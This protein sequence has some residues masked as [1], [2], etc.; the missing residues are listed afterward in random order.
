MQF[1]P[2]QAPPAVAD[3]V[4]DSAL[5]SI[6][7]GD[8]LGRVWQPPRPALPFDR[9]WIFHLR[10]RNSFVLAEAARIFP[11]QP[12]VP[13]AW[14]EHQYGA[15][16]DFPF[17]PES[18]TY[19]EDCAGLLDAALA[20]L[21]E[22][23]PAM[24]ALCLLPESEVRQAS[25]LKRA[26]FRPQ[27]RMCLETEILQERGFGQSSQ[28]VVLFSTDAPLFDPATT[29]DPLRQLTDDPVNLRIFSNAQ[30]KIR[31]QPTF[32]FW[33]AI[34]LYTTY[35]AYPFI[36]Q[37]LERLHSQFAIP[38][39]RRLLVTP[40]AGG[41]FLRLWPRGSGV[42]D[43]AAAVDIRPDLLQIAS[44]RLRVPEVDILNLA[45]CEVL[46]Q[47]VA[48]DGRIEDGL[49]EALNALCVSLNATSR[50]VA[51]RYDDPD[52]LP[53][54]ARAFDQILQNRAIPDW[55]FPLKI[56]ASADVAASNVIRADVL[57][58]WIKCHAEAIRNAVEMLTPLTAS[59][60]DKYR[61]TGLGSV[62]RLSLADLTHDET[63]P[64][65]P[66]DLILCWE[67]IHVF[68]D[69][70]A[71]GRFIDS[72]LARL[73]P[74]GTLVITNIRELSKRTPHEQEWA[75]EHLENSAV[76][77]RAGFV[78]ISDT[79]T[80]HRLPFERRL[81]AQYPVLVAHPRRSE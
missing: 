21:R 75:R 25:I 66:F 47:V 17:A 58:G 23:G 18:P 12:L 13:D 56:L 45:L 71:L 43:H 34:Q 36:P 15:I 80:M 69:F 2:G 5:A 55:Y 39:A 31:L 65:G 77:Y 14:E 51:L 62:T 35:S 11:V 52:S 49:Q 41:D 44:L 46:H 70:A 64:Q 59:I 78:A 60:R 74:G 68:H 42:P 81:H 48:G 1:A 24:A 38:P 7:D 73:A 3:G 6:A 54:I 61:N 63:I 32:E 28:R 57:A 37:F 76:P 26:G 10:G 40:C 79:E 30:T 20:A 19:D 27:E 16:V 4:I 50:R 53:L 67:F 8:A 9:F 22:R 33:G 72:L 29:P